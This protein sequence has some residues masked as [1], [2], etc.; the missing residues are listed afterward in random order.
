MKNVIKRVTATGAWAAS[1]DL[2]P[3]DLPREGIITEITLRA[4]ITATLTAAAYDDWFRRVVQ[5]FK[6]QGDGGKTYLGLG[7]ALAGF[8]LGTLLSL[9]GEMRHKMPTVSSNGAGIALAAPDVGSTTFTSVFKFHPGSNP[10][11]PFDLT[12]GIP[13]RALSTLQALIAAPAAAVTDGAGNIT[14]GTYRLEIAEVNEV[15]IPAGLMCPVGSTLTYGHTGNISDFGYGIDVP[16]GAWLRSIVICVKDDTATISRRKD[17]EVTGIRLR[18]P[19]TGETVLEQ[20]IPEIKANMA[21]RYNWAGTAGDVGPLG[22]IATTRPSPLTLLN[23][24]P[25]GFYVIDLRHFFHPLYGLDL[26]GLQTGDYKLDL[27]I[28]NYAA[29]DGTH[30]YWDQLLPVDPI[31]VGR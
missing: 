16:A 31:Y 2:T 27:T 19:K 13:A 26:R 24:T 18:K 15:A 9:W 5:G 6:I 30:I 14:A 25:A 28:A 10:S 12:A 21:A 22:A 20:L 4:D 8:Q 1:S 29:G 17:D 11:D 23:M 3:I 7:G